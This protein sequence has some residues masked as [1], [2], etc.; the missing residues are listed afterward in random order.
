MPAQEAKLS[1]NTPAKPTL[2]LG[3]ALKRAVAF[4]N[5]N[6]R[7]EAEQMLRAIQRAKPDQFDALHLLGVLKASQ[8][9]YQEGINF[10]VQALKINPKSAEAFLNLG[11][12]LQG[13]KRNEEA[14]ASYDKALA[15][16]S[17]YVEALSNRGVVLRQF[18]RDADAI[19]SYDRALAIKPDYA[20]ALKNR[21][22]ILSKMKKQ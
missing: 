12:A 8:G 22:H 17:D 1:G 10:L 14:L 20:P 6:K 11:N 4:M 19:E 21:D 9:E 2:T 5:A 15:I 18:G 16:K 13:A 3:D 7:T